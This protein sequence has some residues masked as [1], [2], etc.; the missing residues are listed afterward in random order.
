[1]VSPKDLL[2]ASGIV[3]G[4]ARVLN[5]ATPA[6]ATAVALLAPGGI[7]VSYGAG[8]D[9][10]AAVSGLCIHALYDISTTA[11]DPLPEILR[12]QNPMRSNST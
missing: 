12:N 5:E 2:F 7:A 9:A 8:A 11:I 6:I 3:S 10:M 1:M 4:S